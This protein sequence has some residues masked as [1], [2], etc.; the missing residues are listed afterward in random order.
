MYSIVNSTKKDSYKNLFQGPNVTTFRLSSH[1][2]TDT[3]QPEIV[4]NFANKIYHYQK[5]L[6]IRIF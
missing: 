5:I 4:T 3:F 1:T 2:Q 6:D